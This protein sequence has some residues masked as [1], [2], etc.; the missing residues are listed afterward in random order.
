MRMLAGLMVAAMLATWACRGEPADE[1]PA[2]GGALETGEDEAEG[3]AVDTAARAE[4]TGPGQA[5]PK[6]EE[7]MIENAMRAAPDAVAREAKIVALDAD[8]QMRTLREGAGVF[9]CMPDNPGTPGNDPMCLDSNGVTW[10]EAYVS[11]TEPPQDQIG[12]GY[13]LAGGSDASNTDPYA[14]EPAPG[15]DWVDT[16]PH[17]MIFGAADDMQGYPDQ[18]GDARK[19]YVMWPGTP[20]AHIMIPVE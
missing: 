2:A 6:T 16:G 12:F 3:A 10:L 14:T 13:M 5:P 19:P 20:Y 8:G 9:T 17:V 18:A 15:Q 11:R 1:T 4:E 7:E